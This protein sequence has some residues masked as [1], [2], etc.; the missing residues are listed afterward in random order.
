MSSK[1]ASAF[2]AADLAALTK[3][4]EVLAAAQATNNKLVA[5][6]LARLASGPASSKYDAPA[7]AEAPTKGKRGRPKSE[8]EPKAKAA[9]PPAE[10]GTIRFGSASEGEYKEFSSFFKAPFKVAGKEYLS[11]ANYFHSAKFA[12]SDDDFAED[13]RTQKNPALTRAKASSVKEH[14]PIE[15]WDTGKT[16]IMRRGLLAKFSAH[17]AL[18]DKLLSTGDAPLESTIDE[19]MRV[20]GFWSIGEDG[21]GT[22]TM[23]QLLMSVRAELSAGGAP[24]VKPAAPAAKAVSK[25]AAPAP[26]GKKA[27]AAPKAEEAEADSGSDSDTDE[28][29]EAPAPKAKPAAPKAAPA[30]APAA[31]EDED[32]DS[33]SDE[34]EEDDE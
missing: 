9:P 30:P 26:A 32:E 6:V 11:L 8:K 4:I 2:G 13:I 27:A 24:K 28:E 14:A 15:D 34:D 31:D 1:T 19:E 17:S 22:N 16:A 12:G 21:S 18:R 10:D 25:P 23:G 29:D 7:S 5:S 20:K 3:A 33:D